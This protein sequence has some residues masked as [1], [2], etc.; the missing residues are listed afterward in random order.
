[1]LSSKVKHL[2]DSHCPSSRCLQQIK[3]ISYG[4]ASGPSEK[5]WWLFIRKCHVL[6]FVKKEL[7]SIIEQS[8]H[9]GVQD[10]IC[11]TCQGMLL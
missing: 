8:Q 3:Y 5:W 2:T 11:K 6:E 1:M 7:K 4:N 10:V 9:Y